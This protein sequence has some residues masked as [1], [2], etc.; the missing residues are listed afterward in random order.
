M[1]P[2]KSGAATP[3]KGKRGK[4]HMRSLS[5]PGTEGQFGGQGVR[6]KSGNFSGMVG[7]GSLS[8]SSPPVSPG[9]RGGRP[10][11]GS[12]AAASS[13]I[14]RTFSEPGVTG[15]VSIQLDK[16]MRIR[17]GEALAAEAE[18]RQLSNS[19]DSSDALTDTQTSLQDLITQDKA[20]AVAQIAELASRPDAEITRQT[21]ELLQQALPP[22]T[23]DMT[24]IAE[25]A[26]AVGLVT[27][28]HM[29]Q[30]T[31]RGQ[32]YVTTEAARALEWLQVRIKSDSWSYAG[33]LVLQQLTKNA[34]DVIYESVLRGSAYP[35]F[36][37]LLLSKIHDSKI[38]IREASAAALNECLQ[39]TEHREGQTR[40]RWYISI[41]QSIHDGLKKDKS[42]SIHG[43]LLAIDVVVTNGVFQKQRHLLD[44][45][46]MVGKLFDTKSSMHTKILV[47]V[48]PLLVDELLKS[49]T[50][51]VS[52]S[53]AESVESRKAEINKIRK[54]FVE[55][56]L[57]YLQR[58]LRSFGRIVGAVRS[59]RASD[60]KHHLD[61]L[62]QW[63]QKIL[64]ERKHK[65]GQEFN[66]TLICISEVVCLQ[67]GISF[68]LSEEIGGLLDLMFEAGLSTPLVSALQN[69]MF[70]I[71]A[72][73]TRVTQLLLNMI[74]SILMKTG[75]E[76]DEKEKADTYDD[77][78]LALKVMGTF[79]FGQVTLTLRSE[80]GSHHERLAFM[81]ERVLPFLYHH[82]AHVR[83]LAG[84][85]CACQLSPPI[86]LDHRATDDK[87]F[88]LAKRDVEDRRFS[89]VLLV[90][91]RYRQLEAQRVKRIVTALL[92]VCVSDSSFR[93]R[94]LLLNA[95]N[96][97][98]LDKF[99]V[100]EEHSSYICRMFTDDTLEVK[101]IALNML[102]RLYKSYATI[103]LPLEVTFSQI[104]GQLQG[105]GSHD[106][107]QVQLLV[108][109][110]RHVPQMA[111]THAESIAQI[112]LPWFERPA[113]EQTP[114]TMEAVGE[115]A[116]IKSDQLF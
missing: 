116:Q 113:A 93:V 67:S 108:H 76:H 21:A 10:R 89:N 27:R 68:S 7:G 12:P 115:L 52:A 71:K 60:L 83:E 51:S 50:D 66:D 35:N 22:N 73:R 5:L 32:V 86:S 53:T 84:L 74:N 37:E 96:T 46:I 14:P 103:A 8:P 1:K 77:V 36:F 41:H 101:L 18:A 9:L 100:L 45:C 70:H 4:G 44:M 90:K 31:R 91:P 15:L 69:I 20:S 42:D 111:Q 80:Q 28:L 57:K 58:A 38:T 97:S 94:V 33:L 54:I 47:K 55:G 102:G 82:A 105:A 19:G 114:S 65:G 17:R 40:E 62:F 59:A 85:A 39:L 81:H 87:L 61:W 63:A 49:G 56:T 88:E 104:L 11:T 24:L 75:L 16:M 43:S 64:S 110:I 2:E 92:R 99:L 30:T 23:S 29:K 6:P 78:C 106:D 25:A 34:P 109:F 112:V 95:L 26:K 48:L 98:L 3:S 13:S 72:L 107:Q 79:E